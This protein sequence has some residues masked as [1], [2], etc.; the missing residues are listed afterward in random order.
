MR[1]GSRPSYHG[2]GSPIVCFLLPFQIVRPGT[3]WERSAT[4][5]RRKARMSQTSERSAT[6][7][8]AELLAAAALFSSGGAI[9]KS[10]GPG[11]LPVVLGRSA[12]AAIALLLLVP[13]SRRG[14]NR[15]ILPVSAAYAVTMLLFVVSNKL[16]TAASTVFLQS[17][18]PIYVLLLSPWL[19]QERISRRDV[20]FM[21]AL[22]V[23]LA[24]FFARAESPMETAPRPVLGNFLAV[25]S[26]VTWAGLVMGLR[27]LARRSPDSGGGAPAAVVTGNLLACFVCLPWAG[28]LLEASARDWALLAYLGVFQI[29]AAYFLL[30]RGVARVHALE[31]SLLLLLEPVLSPVWA[32]SVHGETVS[33]GTLAG[34]AIILAA[35][36]AHILTQRP[37]TA[38]GGAPADPGRAGEP[39]EPP[40]R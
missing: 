21:I 18:A 6:W 11:G 3:V 37:E 32:W 25:L 1:P 16:T 14:W 30:M 22:A 8:R 35:S 26:G 33:W 29:G 2:A 34:G 19:L 36:I 12:L 17:T 13:A 28:P 9:I 40:S 38:T 15:S 27:H 24:F 31:S 4:R 23:G 39:G 10:I 20:A 7:A 5:G